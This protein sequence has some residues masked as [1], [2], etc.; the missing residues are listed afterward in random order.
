MQ[1]LSLGRNRIM[2]YDGIEK[3]R[4]LANLSVINLEDNP[5]A[6][7][8]DNPTR[9]YVAA[10]LPKIKYYNYTLIDDET[11]AS[12]REKYSRELR[13]LEEIESE[14]LMRREKLQKDTEEEVLLGKCFVEF[15]IQQR[16]FD[17]LF[18][19]WDNALNVDE[20][21]L[22][23]QEEFR[24]K[25]VVIAKELRDIAV[26]EHER[27]Q[28]EI[29]AFKNC[30]EDARKETQSKA[31]RLIETYLEEKEESSL[32]TSSTSERL[33]EMWKS[34]MEE[35]VLLFE[36]I[37][38][39]IEGFRTSL[40]NLIGE[41]FQ[42]AQTC[43]NRIREA[44]SVYLDALE[45]AVTEFIMLKITSNR[46]NEIPAD[47]KDSDSIAS[48]IIQMG[49]RQRLKIDETKRVLVEKAK[50]WVKEFICELHEEEVQRNR[51]N[52]VEINYFLDYEREIITE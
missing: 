47:L 14:E 33:D 43:L 6:M 11:R 13:K 44:D 3:L 2:T 48:K 10:F 49:Q 1:I 41:F 29:R 23:L 15:L 32:D 25:Y 9:E 28:E 20:K 36:N 16:L 7:D 26:Q 8:E 52:I 38:A 12:A 19:P 34:L 24:Q 21:S 42:R 39:G 45:E 40:E 31:Q 51:N 50:V 37:V 22:Q 5:I 27:R 46:E 17:T 30:I 4:S 35:E 18:E